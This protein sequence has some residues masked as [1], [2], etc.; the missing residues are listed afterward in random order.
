MGNGMTE[1]QIQ[2]AVRLAIGREPDLV[3]W[4]NNCGVATIGRSVIRYGV[5]NPGGSDLIG[6]YRGRFIAVEIKR[7]GKKP[8]AEQLLFA[9]LVRRKGGEYVVL[10]SVE[11]AAQWL[12]ELRTRYL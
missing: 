1:G 8:T 10:T 9:S 3:M 6:L 4:R 12:A 2:D 7:P 5:G 11:D